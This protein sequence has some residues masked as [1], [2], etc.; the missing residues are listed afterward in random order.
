MSHPFKRS[1]CMKLESAQKNWAV[2]QL[3]GGW[4]E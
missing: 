3:P 4:G 1:N 2:R